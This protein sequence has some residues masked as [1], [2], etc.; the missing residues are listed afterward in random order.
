M[1]SI[2]FSSLRGRVAS[3]EAMYDCQGRANCSLKLVIAL[4]FRYG[5]ILS[6]NQFFSVPYSFIQFSIKLCRLDSWKSWAAKPT[7]W[8]LIVRGIGANSFQ[9]VS[10]REASI[11]AQFTFLTDSEFLKP[12]DFNIRDF[13]WKFPI[14]VLL[15]NKAGPFEQGSPDFN[16]PFV[17]KIV[18]SSNS[19]HAL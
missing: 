4:G 12:M 5:V 10:I 17:H 6:Q 9:K 2:T 16:E 14:T 13:N 3:K 11:V 1:Q 7:Q 19:S 8:E 18:K 15:A